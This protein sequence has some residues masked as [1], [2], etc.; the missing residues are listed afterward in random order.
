M[1][2]IV[3]LILKSIQYTMDKYILNPAYYMRKDGNRVILCSRERFKGIE[4]YQECF[5]FIHPIN[6][7]MLTF[8]NGIDCLDTIKEKVSKYF[9]I[10]AEDVDRVLKMYVEN[11]ECFSVKHKDNWMFFPEN[12]VINKK[13][14]TNYD[15][16]NIDDFRFTGDPDLGYNRLKY[17]LSI[18]LLL[19]MKCHTDCIYC[20]AN[21]KMKLNSM[22]SLSQI[23]SIIHQAK[24]IGVLNFDINGGEVLLHPNYKEII[25]ALLKNN[26]YPLISTKVPISNEQILT[27]EEIGIHSFQISLDSVKCD[28]LKRLLHVKDNYFNQMKETLDNLDKTKIEIS[29]HT[30][31][32]PLNS[33]IEEIKSLFDFLS[34]Y[35]CVKKIQF[36]PAGYSL[37]CADD[38]TKLRPTENFLLHLD[39]Y[40]NNI[41]E[42]YPDINIRISYSGTKNEYEK[43][44]REAHFPSRGLCTANVRNIVILPDGRVTICEELYEHPHFIIGDLTKQSL[45]EVWNSPKA[46][47]LYH[48]KKSLIRKE[49]AC[50]KCDSFDSC[51]SDRGVCWK[52]I[53]MAYG[54]ENWDYPDPRCPKA[55]PIFNDICLG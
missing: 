7:Q 8:F 24:E 33:S 43:E 21:R 42:E 45:V 5:T 10:P 20:Y 38:Y 12:I 16:Y 11:K 25:S 19:T 26:Y 4:H 34:Q 2:K 54:T 55:P 51:R 48:I 41:R 35:K 39:D 37:Y 27:L 23:I 3:Y 52:V 36:S 15:I 18:N 46:L 53:L 17:P 14:T 49:S 44:Y 6:A 32:T 13:N 40:L 50:K 29:I 22:L 31:I 47:E 28:T 30:I 1:D 9:D